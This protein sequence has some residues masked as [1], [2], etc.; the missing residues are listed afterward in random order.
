MGVLVMLLKKVLHA[1]I[2]LTYDVMQVYCI[3]RVWESTDTKHFGK[4]ARKRIKQ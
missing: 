2:G 4:L 3:L 1:G